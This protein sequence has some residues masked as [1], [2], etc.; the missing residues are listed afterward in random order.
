MATMDAN[1]ARERI[2]SAM[3]YY[4]GLG[5]PIIPLCSHDHLGYPERHK[6]TC[7]QAG[8][9]PLIK[10]W[11]NHDNTTLEDIKGW[12]KEFKNF[13]IGLPLGHV[14][15]FVGIDIDGEQGEE[16]LYEMSG[17]DLPET[18]E[19]IT[20]AGRR[21]L[22]QI[23][24][25][26]QT[27]K[28]VN[29][30]DGEHQ[31]CS[32]LAA[33]QQTVLP[34]SIHKS[35]RVYEWVEGRSPEDIDCAMAPKWLLDLI[36]A[37]NR[38]TPG[39]S[40][41][42]NLTDVGGEFN[43]TP[44]P[45]KADVYNI[46]DE[47][48]E[49]D[50]EDIDL[51]P[52]ETGFKGKKAKGQTEETEEENRITPEELTQ[53][54]PEGQRDNQ[55]TRIIGHFCAKFRDL[56]KDYIMLMA[57][58]HNQM[59]C[60]PPLE[61]STIE[62]KVNHIWEI[63][64]MKSAQ[65]KELRADDKNKFAPINVA[66][67]VL[68]RLEA[69]GYL[70]CADPK[71]AIIWMT[72]KDKGPWRHYNVAGAGGEFQ[73]FILGPLSNP[74]LGGQPHWSTKKNFGDVINAILA[75]LR[76]SGRIWDVNKQ[77]ID[78]QVLKDY[79][80]IPLAGGKLLDWRTGEIMPWDPTTYFTYTIPVEYDPNAKAPNWEKRLKEWLP[81][82]GSRMIVQEFIGYS[83]IPYM[84]F[85]KA[86]M[87]IGEGA[88]G[89][90][91]FLE[92]IQGMLGYE[93]V[94][95]INMRTLFSRFGPADLLGKI[96]NVVNEA[97]SEY[98]RGSHADDFKNLV[99]G[100]RITADVKNKAPLT[101]NNTA[102]FIFA[103]NHDVKTSDKSEGWLRRM[104]IVPFEQDFSK[105]NVPKYEIMQELRQEYPGIFNWALEGLRRLME[106][107]Q[108]STS[109]S[110]E[111]KMQE[112]RYKNDITADFFEHCLE[113]PIVTLGVNGKPIER[114]TATA[115]VEL[116]FKLWIQYK[117]STLQKDRERLTEYLQKKG[118]KKK[119]AANPF[120]STAAKTMCWIN[121]KIKIKDEGFLEELK[122]SLE[123]TPILREYAIKR[124]AELDGEA[125]HAAN[126][127]PRKATVTELPNS[128]AGNNQ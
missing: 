103:A 90:S 33:G 18:W 113:G 117:E 4:V 11:Q 67:V 54:I 15:G 128:Q 27:K 20:G 34:P 42:Y 37:D 101:F 116:L 2:R 86:L 106:N 58:N 92:T 85:E 8:K 83:L 91:L 53:P 16:L 78:T 68:N 29:A 84:G 93:V 7:K 114:G 57:K 99:S 118:F 9:I 120:M 110:V 24:V 66:Q 115:T 77:H 72:K 123:A 69:D 70:L 104:L 109:A 74:E 122:E 87:L 71:E 79:K 38:R 102:K 82:E 30:G 35:G 97:G 47:F 108:F 3:R 21:L 65:Y 26:M 41:T 111:R 80:Y 32:I 59:F 46:E 49:F 63:E 48:S 56:G 81:E 105:S 107:K 25:G 28:F 36:R 51:T 125:E 52:P 61:D 64:Q 43:M 55:M 124:L 126:N 19:Y 12:I 50:P 5:L 94:S 17:G 13:N 10:N 39:A 127:A 100:G 112:Y 119:R 40:K 60:K 23:P 31:E 22:Y 121:L 14:S 75:T 98:L 96:I 89:K 76:E 44:P 62:A 1:Q 45:M 95:S 88:N 6:A 73:K